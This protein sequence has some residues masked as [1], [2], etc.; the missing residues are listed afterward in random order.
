MT[1]LRYSLDNI[2][3]PILPIFQKYRGLEKKCGQQE[4]DKIISF[5]SDISATESQKLFQRKQHLTTNLDD[6]NQIDQ[7]I[8][9][10]TKFIFDELYSGY[11]N[12][13]HFDNDPEKYSQFLDEYIH[14]YYEPVVPEYDE[15]KFSIKF[16]EEKFTVK[17]KWSGLGKKK[18]KG[19]YMKHLQ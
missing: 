14:C 17:T 7:E 9:D 18:I 1:L 4:F 13:E 5:A 8:D 6:V 2:Y 3:Y 12:D 15:A 10:E 11:I 16:F 19:I